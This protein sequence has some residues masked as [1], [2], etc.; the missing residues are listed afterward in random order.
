MY[1]NSKKISE[2]SLSRSMPHRNRRK[3]E[4]KRQIFLKTLTISDGEENNP[5]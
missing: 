4:K 1:H 3:N 2:I 5:L